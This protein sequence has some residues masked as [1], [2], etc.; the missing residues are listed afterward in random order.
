[1]DPSEEFRKK[2]GKS[3]MNANLKYF[4]NTG[5]KATDSDTSKVTVAFLT[6][7]PFLLS[8]LFSV[9]FSFFL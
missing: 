4:L 7:L 8:V 2:Q 3:Q 9:Y 5:Y 6:H 1:M